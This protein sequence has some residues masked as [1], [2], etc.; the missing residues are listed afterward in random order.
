MAKSK[1]IAQG[2]TR[3]VDVAQIECGSER[4]FSLNIAGFGFV[5]DVGK[6]AVRLKFAG[7]SAY[8]L[9]T[10]WR[11][12]R[13]R[14]HELK[15]EVDGQV[16][17]QDNLFVEVSNSRYT[18][19]SFLIAPAAKIDDGRLDIILARRLP[20][21]RLLRLFPSVFKGRHVGFDEVTML[22][23][24][25]ITIHSPHGLQLMVDGEFRGETPARIKCL[26]GAV[27]VFSA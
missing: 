17:A 4:F 3:S 20:R 16:I 7:R 25:D 8:T 14:S 13:L 2:V 15:I 21:R 10:L 22:Q 5:T 12:L 18:G 6:T 9:A 1:L 11:C 27:E 26:P 24:S 23:G 19:T